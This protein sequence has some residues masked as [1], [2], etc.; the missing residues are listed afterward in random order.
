MKQRNLP[1]ETYDNEKF[2][3]NDFIFEIKELV[4]KYGETNVFNMDETG[5]FYKILL[6]KTMCKKSRKGYTNLDRI[7]IMLCTNMSGSRK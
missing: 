1:G 6:S 4:K 3:Y 7:S 2:D 5:L